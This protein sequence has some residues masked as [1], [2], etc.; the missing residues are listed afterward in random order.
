VRCTLINELKSSFVTPLDREDIF[1][2]S[3]S[4]DVV[5]NYTDN[6]IS[7][8]LILKAQ[9]TQYMRRKAT[10]LKDAAYESCQAVLRLQK[11][12]NVAI[13]QAQ[14]SKALENRVEEIYREALAELFNGRED[15]HHMVEMLK[16]HEV[17]LHLSNAA[18]HGDEA[19]NIIADV[20]VKKT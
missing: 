2:L 6:T 16:L 3:R 11:H 12:P 18:D 8:L 4:I 13:D 7:E 1:A 20:V 9:T 14:R 15:I 10:F 19:A 5:I 17:Y